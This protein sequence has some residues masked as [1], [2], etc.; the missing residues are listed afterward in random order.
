M[1]RRAMVL[2]MAELWWWLAGPG[3]SSLK[4]L[5][6]LHRFV[7]FVTE[8]DM[9]RLGVPMRCGVMLWWCDGLDVV[10]DGDITG[11]IEEDDW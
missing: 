5:V 8:P 1:P 7:R 3:D 11:D 2:L 6:E 4:S 10:G 9:E